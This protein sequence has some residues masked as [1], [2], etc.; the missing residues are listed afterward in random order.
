M[1]ATHSATQGDNRFFVILPKKGATFR[2]GGIQ[3]CGKQNISKT[4]I[5]FRYIQPRLN[6]TPGWMAAVPLKSTQGDPRGEDDFPYTMGLLKGE[7]SER[8]YREYRDV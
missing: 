2:S 3:F 6:W 8:E 7:Q 5:V 1:I 4:I